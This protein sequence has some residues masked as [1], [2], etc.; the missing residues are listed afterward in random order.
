M[1]D[2][3]A[4][5]HGL[6]RRQCLRV[7]MAAPLL[8]L[9]AGCG[10]EAKA[11]VAEAC[12]EVPDGSADPGVSADASGASAAT[13]Q[14][15][16][17]PAGA[18]SPPLAPRDVFVAHALPEQVANLGE[19]SMNFATSGSAS[20]PALLLIPGQTES[21]WG[22][23]A[24]MMLLQDHFQVYAV[25]LRGQ[26]RSTWTP[27]RYTF[28]NI[29]NDLVRF[30]ERVIR[31]PVVVCGNSSGG[32]LACWLAAYA[33]PGQL[34][35]ALLEDPPLWASLVNPLVPPG[36]GETLGPV[37]SLLSKYLGDQWSINDWAGLQMAAK[38]DP[39]PLV[40]ALVSKSGEPPQNV[41][42]YDPEWGRVFVDGTMQQTC[43]HERLLAAVKVPVLLTHHF[44]VTL[45]SGELLGAYSD[46]Q[47][48]KA[49]ELLAQTGVPVAYRSFPDAAHAMHNA[50]PERY[51]QALKEWAQTLPA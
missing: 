6:T 36:L 10:S 5:R 45:P 48:M 3:E 42:E 32:L 12:G 47:E 31:R 50:D 40:Q 43:E 17:F 41:K 18:T 46:E 25:D 44:R 20:N 21:W 51:A 1:R 30:I 14:C 27:G 38:A 39:S 29:G 35:G 15:G 34:R 11:D 26:G 22:Y 24:A 2:F 9:A 13:P 16:V 37:F 28:N 23:E 4:L 7:G 49:R 19:I 33:L 8:T